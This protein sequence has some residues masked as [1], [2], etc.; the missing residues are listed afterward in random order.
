MSPG[1]LGAK[2]MSVVTLH[3]GAAVDTG[4]N[5]FGFRRSSVLSL[6]TG[7][8][9][10]WAAPLPLKKSNI[11]I[12]FIILL[13]RVRKTL[14]L[15]ISTGVPRLS[16]LQCGCSVLGECVWKSQNVDSLLSVRGGGGDND[17][18]S[19]VMVDVG[20]VDEVI[21]FYQAN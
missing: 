5:I 19:V 13:L 1:F 4:V 10:H 20:A 16:G 2:V 21:V 9:V 8:H 7:S 3:V 6:S 11:L 18:P 15:D 17:V 12:V 14:D